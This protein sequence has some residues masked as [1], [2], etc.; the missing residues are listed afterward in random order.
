MGVDRTIRAVDYRAL[1]RKHLED[2]AKAPPAE[3]LRLFRQEAG[4]YGIE[5]ILLG[6]YD[7][8]R[9]SLFGRQRALIEAEAA[10]RDQMLADNKRANR[11]FVLALPMPNGKPLGDQTRADLAHFA[12]IAA[13]IPEGGTVKDGQAATDL[14]TE[15]FL[16][17]A[18]AALKK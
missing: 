13:L 6:E 7:R 2:N 9:R 14:A 3:L 17:D 18:L 1:M 12:D 16:E 8:E 4:K 15:T 5:A 11:L 10:E